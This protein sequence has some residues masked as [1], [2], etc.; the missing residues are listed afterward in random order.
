[1]KYSRIMSIAAV[2]GLMA[3]VGSGAELMR[4]SNSPVHRLP[5]PSNMRASSSANGRPAGAHKA[6]HRAAMKLRRVKKARK[7]ARG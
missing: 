1:M 7:A 3:A 2:A 4:E 5:R 6:A